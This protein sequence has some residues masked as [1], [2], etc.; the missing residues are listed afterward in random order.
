MPR[1]IK[2]RENPQDVKLRENMA[3]IKYKIAVMSGKGGVGKSTISVNLAWSLAMNDLGVGLLD[4]D[5]HGPNIPK[6]LGVAGQRFTG[7]ESEIEPVEVMPNLRLASVA[8]IGYDPDAALIWR[9]PMKL[10]LIKQFLAD[11]VWGALDYLVIDTPPGS[12]DEALTIGQ[13]IKP[14]S[15]VIIVTT[16]QEVALLDSRKTVDFAAKLSIPVIGI[17]ENMADSE[18]LQVFGS[19][20][21]ERAADELGVPF[22]GRVALDP[23]MVVGGDGGRPFLGDFSDSVAGAQLGAIVEQIVAYCKGIDGAS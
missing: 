11:I 10:G 6:M 14:L 2:G 20:G 8:N 21:G 9:G 18:D 13:D 5:I 4:A 12:G 17:V 19:G 16:P 1:M 7:S 3:R 23:R 22:L 15:G